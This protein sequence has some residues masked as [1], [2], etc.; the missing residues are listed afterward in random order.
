MTGQ[1]DA[2]VVFYSGSGGFQ[3]EASM[4]G[5]DKASYP[6]LNIEV[7]PVQERT[8]HWHEKF[9]FQ[10]SPDEMIAVAA[11]FLGQTPFVEIKR[12]MKGVLMERQQGGVYVRASGAGRSIN[13]QLNIGQVARANVFV[14]QRL[15]LSMGNPDP[16]LM[17]HAIK[18]AAALS[19]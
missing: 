13:M 3:L 4:G 12:Q 10:L 9:S 15:S 17:L 14:L 11:M 18:G 5:A 16:T 2:K 6:T 1:Y 8:A 7:C 19:R